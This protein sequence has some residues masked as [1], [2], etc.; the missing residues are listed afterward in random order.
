[1]LEL[2]DKRLKLLGIKCNGGCRV[3]GKSIR[4]LSNEFKDYLANI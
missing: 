3:L 4:D 1:M 2:A